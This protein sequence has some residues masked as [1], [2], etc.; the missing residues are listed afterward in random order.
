[1]TSSPTF[2]LSTACSC[3]FGHSARDGGACMYLCADLLDVA[4]NACVWPTHLVSIG[5]FS[6][7]SQRNNRARK[8]CLMGQNRD[9]H[10]GREYPSRDAQNSSTSAPLQQGRSLR[11]C[12]YQLSATQTWKSPFNQRVTAACH[13]RRR[14]TP[15]PMLHH[16]A[17]SSES[18]ALLTASRDTRQKTRLR[19]LERGVI[20][21][22]R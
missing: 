9:G 12:K 5:S 6:L 13:G 8:D 19:M 10:R 1:M 20:I 4:L 21:Q 18:V 14:A 3:M 2:L 17:S 22:T 15:L 7:A 11:Y 16:Y